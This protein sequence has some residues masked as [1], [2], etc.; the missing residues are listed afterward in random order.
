[1][2]LA[3][4]S[5][6]HLRRQSSTTITP[7]YHHDSTS[8]S[9][10]EITTTPPNTRTQQWFQSQYP[11]PAPYN[12]LQVDIPSQAYLQQLGASDSSLFTF[13]NNNHQSLQTRLEPGLM[14]SD[15]SVLP[16]TWHFSNGQLTPTSARNRE[17]SLSSLG[18]AG[19]ASPYNLSTS[20]P[21]VVLPS[22]S[23]GEVYYDGLP[24]TDQTTYHNLSKTPS[25]TLQESYLP[26]AFQHNY[27]L[28]SY[29]SQPN[30]NTLIAM[31]KRNA[32]GE[33]ETMSAPD[34]GHSSR[35]SVAS[36]NDSPATPTV[37]DD[38]EEQNRNKMDYRTTST[39]PKLDR[40]MS[41]AYN[42]ELYSPSFSFTSAPPSQSQKS[43]LSPSQ[44]SDIFSQRLQAATSQHLNASSQAALAD[45]SRGRSPFRQ[46]SPL[47]PTAHQTFSSQ[48][49]PQVRLGTAAQMRVQQKAVNDARVLEEQIRRSTPEQSAPKT[50]SPKDALLDYHET[51]EEAAMPLFPP[52]QAPQYRFAKPTA[53]EPP[54]DFDDSAS[55]QSFASMATSRRQSSSALSNT[56]QAT[57]RNGFA[58]AP[59]SVPGS[60]Q[61]PQQYP[62]VPQQRQQASS[63]T[64]M[65]DR[66]PEFPSNLTSMESS[67][68]EYAPNTSDLIKPA[69]SNADGG[70]YT[71]TYHGCTLRFET[72]A[73][74][75]K[76]K[77]EGHRQS[78]PL[79]GGAGARASPVRGEG[80]SGM[81]SAALLRN[82][83]AGP[84]KCERIN[85]STGKP[86]NTIF[87]R[88]YDLTRHEDTIHNA[89]KQK[90]RCHLCTEEKTFSRNDALTRHMR[91]VH[92][93]VDFPGKH[94][95]RG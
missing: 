34:Y 60:V 46:G 55:Q 4:P 7:P 13:G 1:M 91:V 74:L 84:H 25:Q 70:T 18:S 5:T 87:S 94:R 14:Q 12:H 68:S 40:T 75:Q 44:H 28:H 20:H 93:E 23:V 88:P 64:S 69:R 51:E 16:T 56:S 79:I 76:H 59:P 17:S 37:G 57:Q 95:R 52:Q 45:Q 63:T 27:N 31:N 29:N 10:S 82:S 92:P 15:H 48:H 24:V 53:Q 80:S 11:D 9:Y 85:P 77:R 41:D 21:Q 81:T 39:I 65:A 6:S 67:C 66:T 36:T 26:T 83:Q 61:V 3:A 35:P 2:L 32:N 86:C 22:D 54:S 62:F 58:F 72:P 38:F 90:V 47:A 50:I 8:T 19:P 43:M 71:C 78:V 89:R 33:D 73:K 49:S 42:D 30:Y